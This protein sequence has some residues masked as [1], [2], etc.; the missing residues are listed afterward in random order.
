[1]IR[2]FLDGLEGGFVSRSLRSY[3]SIAGCGKTSPRGTETQSLFLELD[4]IIDTSIV[5]GSSR[6]L[7]HKGTGI[8][9]LK[10][11]HTRRGPMW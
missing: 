9:S 6:S 5:H 7:M 3:M 8:A 10:L 1:M 2:V 4:P 11:L